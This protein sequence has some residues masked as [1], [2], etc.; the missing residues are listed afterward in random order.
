MDLTFSLFNL[1][2]LKHYS[3]AHIDVSAL[4][5]KCGPTFRAADLDLSLSSRDADLLLTVRTCIDMIYP[6]LL[7]DILLLL[8]ETADLICLR[9]KCLIL[10]ITF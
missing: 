4:L 6:S 1:P 10:R 8:E 9:K 5:N 7:P 3:T 2:C